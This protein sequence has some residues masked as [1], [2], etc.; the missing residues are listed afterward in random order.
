MSLE[1]QAWATG[2]LQHIWSKATGGCAGTPTECTGIAARLADFARQ[3]P[4]DAQVKSSNW[5]EAAR[6]PAE[7]SKAS[8]VAAPK[9]DVPL[10]PMRP[11]NLRPARSGAM[12]S[13]HAFGARE[14]FSQS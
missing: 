12:K 3:H 4:F 6:A 11:R 8:E 14:H 2:A 1:L 13:A 5:A 9:A 7:V 10:P